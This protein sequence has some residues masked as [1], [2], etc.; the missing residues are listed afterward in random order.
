MVPSVIVLVGNFLVL[1]IS[2]LD[3]QNTRGVGKNWKNVQNHYL[4]KNLNGVLSSSEVFQILEH[5]ACASPVANE[6]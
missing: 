6:E 5:C 3:F 2:R 4:K 1:Y